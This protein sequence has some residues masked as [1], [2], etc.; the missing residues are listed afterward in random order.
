MHTE[1]ADR[2]IY[3]TDS[4]QSQH[5]EMVFKAAKYCNIVP[6]DCNV[7]IEHVPF[8][9][10][11]GEDGKKIK[12]RSGDSIKLRELLDEAIRI[13]EEQFATRENSQMVDEDETNQGQKID[14][15]LSE[16]DK[17]RILGIAAVKYADLSMN[18]ESS[19]KFSFDKML[20]LNGNTAP[21]MLYAYVRIRGIQRKVSREQEGESASPGSTHLKLQEIAEIS[22]AKHLIRFDSIVEEVANELYP[23][24]VK[25]FST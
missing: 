21:Y 4:G 5:F 13:A 15:A 8:G 1:K 12:S 18:R 22:L 2:I 6:E 17:A 10:V 3:V 9:L 25:F 23:H 7:S 20:S 11:L 19:Y 16:V 14:D 24:K